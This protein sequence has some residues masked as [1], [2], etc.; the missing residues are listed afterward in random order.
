MPIAKDQ[1]TSAQPDWCVAFCTAQAD[2]IIAD[3][4]ADA[5]NMLTIGFK[6]MSP[7]VALS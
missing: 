5:T 3:N 2:A 4:T 1:K 7:Q 6:K